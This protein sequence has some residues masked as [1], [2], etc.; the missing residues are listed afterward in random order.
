MTHI[1]RLNRKLGESLGFVRGGTQPR[2]RWAWGPSLI[3]WSKHLSDQWV[4][5]HWD[6][7]N[8]PRDRWNQEFEGRYPYPENGMYH[9]YVE[10][11]LPVGQEP[12]D[13]LTQKAIRALDAQMSTTFA[14]EMRS[15]NADMERQTQTVDDEWTEYVQNQNYSAIDSYEQTG[16]RGATS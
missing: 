9:A 5:T 11:A 4:M 16:Y 3:F 13:E 1:D 14:K 10:W 15:V 6:K 2:F 7:P 12:N 8:W